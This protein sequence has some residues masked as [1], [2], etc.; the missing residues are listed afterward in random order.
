M[1]GA[2]NIVMS[3]R[4][5]EKVLSDSLAMGAMQCLIWRPKSMQLEYTTLVAMQLDAI[6]CF[7]SPS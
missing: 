6:Q 4:G 7:L 5:D 2:Y 3:G 1:P